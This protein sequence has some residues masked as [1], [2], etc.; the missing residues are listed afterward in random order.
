MPYWKNFSSIARRDIL[1]ASGGVPRLALMEDLSMCQQLRRHGNL[2]LADACVITSARRFRQRGVLRTYGLMGWLWL[3]YTLGSP[4]E[5]L[6]SHY[7][8]DKK[9]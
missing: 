2:V 9:T 1:I 8:S 3:R 4:A 6:A 5:T 7:H